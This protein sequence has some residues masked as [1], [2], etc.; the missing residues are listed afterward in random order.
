MSH[1]HK[2]SVE[3]ETEAL[4]IRVNALIDILRIAV[5]MDRAG[6][7]SMIVVG[8]PPDIE[9]VLNHRWGGSVRTIL[10]VTCPDIKF[11]FDES[12]LFLSMAC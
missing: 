4:T 1:L 7:D 2:T 9:A 5:D 10:T 8:I 3:K 12:A 6:L 11:Q